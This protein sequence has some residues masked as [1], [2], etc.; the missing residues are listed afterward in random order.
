MLLVVCISLRGC[1][2]WCGVLI[3][4]V[5]RGGAEAYHGGDAV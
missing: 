4:H 5:Y 2:R 3:V 1:R